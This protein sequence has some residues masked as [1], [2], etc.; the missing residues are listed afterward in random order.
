VE[1]ATFQFESFTS[2]PVWPDF[3]VTKLGLA[4]GDSTSVEVFKAFEASCSFILLM[5]TTP[6]QSG[7]TFSTNTF[8]K[9]RQCRKLFPKTMIHVDGGV[10]NEVSF[11]LRD[12]GVYSSVSGSYLMNHES[13]A[14]ALYQLRVKET[15]SQ[16]KIADFMIPLEELPVLPISGTSVKD[17]L[18]LMEQSKYGFVF[19]VDENKRLAGICSNADLRKGL[20]KHLDDLN[21]TSLM[22][23][24]NA[25]PVTV[26]GEY[27]IAQMLQLIH[28]C[29]FPILFLPVVHADG[30]AL[31]AVTFNNLIKGES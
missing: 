3:S 31:G 23:V 15:A 28:N 13:M 21:Q 18:M 6:G 26:L 24:M 11:I 8:T 4:I 30:T 16:F 12:M 1:W 19:F 29:S 22:D 9:I 2:T 27:T 14:A 10:N 7:G 17:V 5:T 25:H 20:I